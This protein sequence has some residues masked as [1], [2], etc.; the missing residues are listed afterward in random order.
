LLENLR[1]DD[2]APGDGCGSE[3]AEEA[4]E[5]LEPRAAPPKDA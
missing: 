2:G 3:A 4:R 1:D 5:A